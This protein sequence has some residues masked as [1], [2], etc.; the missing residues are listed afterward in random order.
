MEQQARANGRHRVLYQP[1]KDPVLQQLALA[2][3]THCG[4]VILAG[5]DAVSPH[6]RDP[7]GHRRLVALDLTRALLPEVYRMVGAVCGYTVEQAVPSLLLD[8]VGAAQRTVVYAPR[9]VDA[10]GATAAARTMRRS[11]RAT[12]P[13][14]PGS[15]IPRRVVV[16]RR[17]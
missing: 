5:V 4:K 17:G 12:P 1:R 6:Q 9:P 2:M 7:D 3:G 15:R 16:N 13:V 8:L 14:A 10:T 11:A